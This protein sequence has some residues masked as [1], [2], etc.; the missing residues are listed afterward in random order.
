M[1]AKPEMEIVLVDNWRERLA[2]IVIVLMLIFRPATWLIADIN[3]GVFALGFI[4]GSFAF[5][6]ISVVISVTRGTIRQ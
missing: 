1:D 5:F 3:A 2:L 6:V 4:S